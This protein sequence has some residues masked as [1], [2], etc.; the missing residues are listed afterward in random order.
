MTSGVSRMY[1]VGAR[2]RRASQGSAKWRPCLVRAVGRPGLDQLWELPDVHQSSGSCRSAIHI[3]GEAGLAACC[4][5]SAHTPLAKNAGGKQFPAAEFQLQRL[6][7]SDELQAS[8]KAPRRLAATLCKVRIRCNNATSSTCG[9]SQ[10]L[11]MSML[12]VGDWRRHHMVCTGDRCDREPRATPR[13]S[14]SI[15]RVEVAVPQAEAARWD[16]CL[17]AMG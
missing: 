8:A 9:G 4:N 3:I 2:R 7:V 1:F 12:R 16:W 17:F 10:C 15:A 14:R 11:N 5:S 6:A 13:R